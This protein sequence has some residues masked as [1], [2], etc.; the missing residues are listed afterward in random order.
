MKTVLLV[1]LLFPVMVWG[2][3]VR[4]T[5]EDLARKQ[6]FLL[7]R[8]GIVVRGQVIRQD[9]LLTTVRK[10]GGNL[11]FV[12]NEQLI[13]IMP[14]RPR[15]N[16]ATTLSYQ[17]FVFR[18]SS[19]VEGRFVRQDSTMITVRKRNGQLTYFEPELLLRVDSVNV[20][21]ADSG[22]TFINQFSPWLLIGQTAYNPEK[23][24]FY[25]RNKWVLLNEVE[26][27]I[28]RNWSVGA[29]YSLN[30]P[31][32]VEKLDTYQATASYQGNTIELNSKL[33]ASI[34]R[35]FRAGLTVAYQP[36]TS[37][38]F[39]KNGKW[40]VQ[41][42][43]TFGTSQRNVTVGYGII[44][45][46]RQNVYPPWS[47]AWPPPYT[48]ERIP[49][50]SFITLGIV[51]KILP[52]LTLLSDNRINL[53]KRFFSYDDRGERATLSF[54][55]RLDRR[56]HSFDLGAYSFLYRNNYFWDG[57]KVRIVPY[58]GYNLMIGGKV[59]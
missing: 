33:S 48:E 6:S 9:S 46:G 59:K 17:V 47:S 11:T 20:A 25:Y 8:D 42:L 18:D 29:S 28:T 26:Y 19:R 14:I 32:F 34:G 56:R 58:I 50:Q 41:A 40:T 1:L 22:R 39:Y 24:R 57:K 35:K 54:A 3:R 31:M 51:Q 45:R 43:A 44:N 5:P 49:D 15:T 7:L 38:Y 21:T 12:E 4:V 27:G 55:L 23:G 30:P 36:K 13:G 52:N 16:G 37:S 2:Q 53:G 10:S